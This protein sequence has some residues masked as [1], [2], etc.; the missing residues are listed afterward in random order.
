MVRSYQNELISKRAEQIRGAASADQGLYLV[1]HQLLKLSNTLGAF[2]LNIEFISET[3]GIY[4]AH[5]REFM[6][7]FSTITE[8]VRARLYPCFRNAELWMGDSRTAFASYLR[9]EDEYIAAI[10]SRKMHA[11]RVTTQF[12]LCVEDFSI[13]ANRVGIYC[14]FH[15]HLSAQVEQ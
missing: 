12:A 4:P 14:G 8:D 3:G 5:R 11:A 15:I 6:C 9:I 2:Q 1:R 13:Y 10:R 7:F